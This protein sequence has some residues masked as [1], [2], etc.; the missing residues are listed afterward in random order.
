LGAGACLAQF[1]FVF[2]HFSFGSLSLN[3]GAL[4]VK[5]LAP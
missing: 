4:L 1:D 2:L 5:H 3:P